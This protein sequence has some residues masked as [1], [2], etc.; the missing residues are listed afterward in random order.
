MSKCVKAIIAVVL[1]N[2]AGCCHNDGC[3]G[4]WH[5]R[6]SYEVNEKPPL[7]VQPQSNLTQ[8]AGQPVTPRAPTGAYGGTGQ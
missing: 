3:C 6:S 1:L 8:P 4:W 5:D 7:P 2:G